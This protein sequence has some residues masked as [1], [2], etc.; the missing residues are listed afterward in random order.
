MNGITGYSTLCRLIL[1]LMPTIIQC[2]LN[3]SRTA[4]GFASN[5]SRTPSETTEHN[6]FTLDPN[7]VNHFMEMEVSVN[8]DSVHGLFRNQNNLQVVKDSSHSK[9]ELNSR[10]WMCEVEGCGRQASFA[11]K[12]ERT[13]KRCGQHRKTKHIDV[14]HRQICGYLDCMKRACFGTVADSKPRWCARHRGP[15]DVPITRMRCCHAGCETHPVYG[16]PTTRKREFCFKHK[17]SHH[18]KLNTKKQSIVR[19]ELY[20]ASMQSYVC[21]SLMTDQFK[22]IYCKD[23]NYDSELCETAIPNVKQVSAGEACDRYILSS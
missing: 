12:G 11:F 8:E 4:S 1:L 19:K 21:L 7:K 15:D 10:S 5:F 13:G 20:A 23:Y 14:R 16:D 22:K 17:A 18:I 2:N 9:S 6:N 3:F